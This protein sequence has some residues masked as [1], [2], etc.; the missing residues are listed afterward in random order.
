MKVVRLSAQHTSR[1]NPPE[2]TAAFHLC[3]RLSRYQ[4]HN[5]TGRITSMSSSDTIE[6]RALDKGQG[7]V[8]VALVLKQYDDLA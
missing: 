6:S 5:A 3:Q 8:Y 2:N 7:H 4:G 1:L